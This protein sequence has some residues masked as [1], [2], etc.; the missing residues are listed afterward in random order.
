M[1][2]SLQKRLERA[3]TD[4]EQYYAFASEHVG[5]A[6][7]RCAANPHV[8]RF[9]RGGAMGAATVVGAILVSR[10]ALWAARGT[11]DNLQHVAAGFSSLH[12]RFFGT[13]AGSDVRTAMEL[14]SEAVVPSE[15]E[16]LEESDALD[17]LTV[18][19]GPVR[20]GFGIPEAAVAGA[21][22]NEGVVPLIQP[23]PD[24]A[25]DDVEREAAR[26]RRR[27][28]GK[29]VA[30]F[31]VKERVYEIT[32]MWARL[33]FEA[34]E[35]YRGV[36]YTAFSNASL[37]RYLDQQLAKLGPNVRVQDRLKNLRLISMF[38]WYV[39]DAEKDL[40]DAFAELRAMGRIRT[41]VD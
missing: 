12:R 21:A 40:Q 33:A 13:R 26:R 41:T 23:H 9:V 2:L 17:A 11:C 16:E 20:F 19:P 15:E 28:P 1:A 24:V 14:L 5:A 8:G 3:K 36:G 22:R 4:A 30:R 10:G 6:G 18:E 34:K 35:H 7:S 37:N 27:Q 32:G 38:V 29:V 25:A 31:M 39:D